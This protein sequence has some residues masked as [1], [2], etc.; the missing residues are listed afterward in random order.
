MS[1]RLIFFVIGCLLWAACGRL[2]DKGSSTIVDDDLYISRHL[3]TRV[4]KLISV[5]DHLTLRFRASSVA[6]R[7]ESLQGIS[8]QPEVAGTWSWQDATT[9]VFVPDELLDYDQEY[10]LTLDMAQ[11]NPQLATHS[12]IVKMRF[13]TQTLHLQIIIDGPAY[14]PDE[15]GVAVSISG[16]IRASDYVDRDL[17][18]RTLTSQVAGDE[19]LTTEWQHSSDGRSHHFQLSGLR[20]IEAAQ[21]VILKWKSIHPIRGFEGSEGIVISAK[22]ALEISDISTITSPTKHIRVL[23]NQPLNTRQVLKGLVSIPG[24]KATPRTLINNNTLIIYPET[25]PEGD[26]VLKIA[27]GIASYDQH[28]LEQSY[29]FDLRFEAAKP[30][31]RASEHGVIIPSAEE[32][33]FSFEAINIDCVYFEIF[34]IYEDNILQFLQDHSLSESYSLDR[35]GKIIHR[36]RIEVGSHHVAQQQNRWQSYELDLSSLIERETNAI[37]QL[38]LGFGP[39]DVRYDC[40]SEIKS[41]YQGPKEEGSIMDYQYYSESYEEWDYGNRDNP[42]SIAYYNPSHFLQRNV[43]FSDI[44]VVVKRGQDHQYRLAISGLSDG[45]PLNNAII[46]MYNFQQQEVARGISSRDGMAIITAEE[47]VAFVSVHH[48]RGTAY[49]R[50]QDGYAQSISDFDTEGVGYGGGIQGYI[51]ADRGVHRP[52][53][54]IYLHF[55]LAAPTEDF[56]LDH[57]VTLAVKDARNQEVYQATTTSHMD[58]IYSFVVPT[59][60]Q[61]ATGLWTAQIRVGQFEKNHYLRVET[62]KPNRLRMLLERP[63]LIHY[64][65]KGERELAISSSWLHGAPAASLRARI[66]GVWTSYEPEFSKFKDYTFYDPARKI[67]SQ[68]ITLFDQQLDAKGKGLWRLSLDDKGS[69]PGFLKGQ[70]TTRIFETG[71]DFSETYQ[72]IDVS[73]YAAYVG[74]KLPQNA[75]GSAEVNLGE[76]AHFSVVSVDADGRS[77]GKRKLS[78]GIYDIDWRWWYYSGDRYKIYELNS[79]QHHRAFYT[80]SISTDADGRIAFSIPTDNMGYGRKLIRIRDEES[81]HCTGSFFYAY[82]NAMSPNDEERNSLTRLN[83]KTDK[84]TYQVGDNAILT[85]PSQIGSRILISV[86]NEKEIL[87]Q[88]WLEGQEGSLQYSL[89]INEAMAPN[90]YAHVTLIQPHQS[91]H[92]DLPIRMYGVAPIMV[93]DPETILQPRIN[94]ASEFRPQQPFAVEIQEERGQEMYYTLA[95]VDEGLL[96]LTNYKTPDP[97]ASFYAKR[98]LGVKTWDMYDFVNYGLSGAPDHILSVGGSDG[99]AVR[100]AKQAIRFRPVVM[101]AGPFH[102]PSGKTMKHQFTMPNYVGSVRVMVVAR[103][104]RAYGHS[105]ATVP[106]R[107][108]LMILPTVPRVLSPGDELQIPVTVFAME[109]HIRTVNTRIASTDNLSFVDAQGRLIFS[110]Q[111]EQTDYFDAIVGDQIGI[112]NIKVTAS[113]ANITTSQDVEVAIRNPNP[114]TT[115]SQEVVIQAG[116]TW[117]GTYETH[118]MPDTRQGMIELS[119]L[120]SIHLAN[121]M[122][123]L[124]RYPYGCIEQTISAAFPQLY[125][126]DLSNYVDKA[127]VDRHIKAAIRRI[128]TMQ[129]SNGGFSYWPGGDRVADDWGT[130]YA[131]HFLIAAGDNEYYVSRQLMN[132]WVNYQQKMARSF[133]IERSLSAAK[134]LD[135]LL[136]QAYRL[137]TLALNGTPELSAMNALRHEL[138]LPATA[139]FLLAAAY[140]MNSKKSIAL[141]LIQ[142]ANTDIEPYLHTSD[143]YGSRIRDMALIAQTL[144]LLD[145]SNEGAIIVKK[146]AHLLNDGSWHSTQSLAHGIMAVAQIGGQGVNKHINASISGLTPTPQTIDYNQT[147]YTMQFDPDDTAASEITVANRGNTPLYMTLQISAQAAPREVLQT[148][149]FNNNISLQVNYKHL[150]GTPIDITRIPQGTD[151]VAEVTIKNLNTKGPRLQDLALTQILP[152]G[153]EIRSGRLSQTET[154]HQDQYEYRDVRDDRVHT[155]FDLEGTQVYSLLLNAAY[156][157]KYVLPPVQIEAMYDKSIQA[158][159]QAQRVTVVKN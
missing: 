72:M 40:A 74:I 2:T 41:R 46:I 21:S 146:I 88:E 159:T 58:Q 48:S 32:L 133:T 8:L 97:H 107:T 117:Q 136:S 35:V 75:W 69:Y 20:Q 86:E 157:G 29:D 81:G 65:Q 17:I 71:G 14:M 79:A 94:T 5:R 108:P 22:G 80:S 31:L 126:A 45:V 91:L 154:M 119:T 76:P 96:D 56:P 132:N 152:S 47:P 156:Q 49:V 102:L 131:G 101:T 127:D 123:Q 100:G 106:V 93:S 142:G 134:Q 60:V 9:A 54:S 99:S 12:D 7:P 114:I 26:F 109:D 37:Y 139:S 77:V 36:E 125:L 10:L 30:A 61:A 153:W 23:F 145:R 135:Q 43:F 44:G 147:I 78:I 122:D 53:D 70:L 85:I 73:P 137:Y 52:G 59:D 105:E 38:R 140:A 150:N 19:D 144:N 39:G 15:R 82:D 158:I 129:L 57:P 92:N 124:I 27:K 25:L 66:E 33:R 148:Q 1:K 28:L 143:T 84:D 149:A 55:M 13:R 121:Y 64:E 90:V 89:P 120:P 3:S 95:I 112:A 6:D 24:Q 98:S 68:T 16:S 130:S 50:T 104:R 110:Q 116:E 51:Y 63:P 42:C 11:V 151:F 155:F 111:G 138:M 118:G 4:P 83:F 62:I 113:A 34:K 115:T 67:T 141:E 87:Y 128:A 103:H 18:E